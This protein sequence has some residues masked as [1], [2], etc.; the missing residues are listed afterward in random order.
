ML[1]AS[2]SSAPEEKSVNL[3]SLLEVVKDGANCREDL[4]GRFG[5]TGNTVDV[6]IRRLISEGWPIMDKSDEGEDA[7]YVMAGTKRNPAGRKCQEPDCPTVLSVYNP[8][9]F[10]FAHLR[11]ATRRLYET[12]EDGKGT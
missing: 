1:V 10:C 12:V 2:A 5:I 11:A 6:S 8:E 4:A 3:D 9:D 7:I